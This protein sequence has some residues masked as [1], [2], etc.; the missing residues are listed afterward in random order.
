MLL[1]LAVNARDAMPGGGV[2]TDPDEER[3]AWR[4]AGGRDG[5]GGRLRLGISVTDTGVGMDQDTQTR[6][7]NPFFTTKES[8]QGTGDGLATVRQIASDSGGSVHLESRQGVGTTVTFAIP[9]AGD[10][11]IRAGAGDAA[12]IEG[13]NLKRC[14]SSKTKPACADWSPTCS[15]WRDTTCSPP[16]PRQPPSRSAAMPPERFTCC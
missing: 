9:R 4:R 5:G 8:H 15:N 13:G 1:N 2:L 7:F 6:A 3:A 10:V 12:A 16:P 14:S 11:P